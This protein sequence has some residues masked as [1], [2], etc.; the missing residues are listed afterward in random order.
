MRACGYTLYACSVTPRT[1]AEPETSVSRFQNGFSGYQGKYPSTV[2]KTAARWLIARHFQPL[3]RDLQPYFDSFPL[4]AV[5][6]GSFAP[7]RYGSKVKGLYSERTGK[8]YDGTVLLCDT[9]DKYVNY[10]IEQR[11]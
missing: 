8:T 6:L 2:E 1:P 7:G 5:A 3:N 11:K 4:A 9:G 10:R